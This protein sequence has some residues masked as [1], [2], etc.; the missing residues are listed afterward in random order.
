MRPLKFFLLGAALDAC[1]LAAFYFY[2]VVSMALALR[3]RCPDIGMDA[4]TR[5]C[6]PS[7][8]LRSY[9]A[10]PLF[11]LLL[12]AMEFWWAAA[13]L[14]LVLPLAGLCYALLSAP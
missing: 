12:L 8:A 3:G 1:L 7:E 4:Y 9:F 11:G 10:W 5:A 2:G 6:P 14:L 13:P